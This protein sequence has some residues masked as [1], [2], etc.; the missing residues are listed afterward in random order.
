ML[1]CEFTE[2]AFFKFLHQAGYLIR[3]GES[4]V[5]LGQVDLRV[6]FS[7][8]KSRDI[9]KKL[10]FFWMSLFSSI[11]FPLRATPFVL[12]DQDWANFS[13]MTTPSTSSK[14]T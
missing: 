4:K 13:W 14:S 3:A 1:R 9:K 10:M 5:I 7:T 12:C 2:W 8:F 11:L 6:L